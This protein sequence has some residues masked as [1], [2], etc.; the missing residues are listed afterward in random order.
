[1]AAARSL[2]RWLVLAARARA[3][4]AGAGLGNRSL[5]GY[6]PSPADDPVEWRREAR[7]LEWLIRA[8]FTA[9][10]ERQA[11]MHEEVVKQRG[12]IAL[13]RSR[14][15]AGYEPGEVAWKFIQLLGTVAV[16]HFTGKAEACGKEVEAAREELRQAKKTA[17]E[18]RRGRRRSWWHPWR[19]TA[20]RE[21]SRRAG[22]QSVSFLF[23]FA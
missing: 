16:R 3:R 4:R 12:E 23:L 14:A 21:R 10:E 19:A 7:R 2:G 20:A 13:F 11:R 6:P 9:L 18:I 15:R 22:P 17:K 8:R 1:M 5:C